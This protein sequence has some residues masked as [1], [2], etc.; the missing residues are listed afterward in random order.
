MVTST[1]YLSQAEKQTRFL[2][3]SVY[4]LGILFFLN[5]FTPLRLHFDM[6]RYFAIKDCIESKCPPGADP[7]DYLPYGYTA[8]LL[9]LSKLGILKSFTIVFVNC[10]Y[11]FG[12]LFF[13]RKIFSYIRSPFLLFFLVLM[14]WTM[15]KFVT[16]PLSE[17]QY[18]FFSLAAIYAF[19]NFIQNKNIWYLLF[20]FL[21]AGLAFLTRTVGVSLVAAIIVS[22]IWEFRK[23]L[24]DIIKKN[25][26]LVFALLICVIIV[27]IFSKQLGLNHYTG[28]MSKQFNEGLRFSDVIGWHFSEWGEI[29]LNTSRFKVISLLSVSFANWIFIISGIL[30][31]SGFVYICFIKK[32]NIPFIVKSYLFFYIIL[33][34]NWPFQDPRFW[35]PVIPL[36]AAVISQ[37]S[38]SKERLSRLFFYL[39]LFVYSGLGLISLAYMTY[40]SF[41]KEEFSK[42][43]AKGVYRNEY[44]THFFG[45]TL[46]DTV[47]RVDP[48]L[49]DFLN[50]YDK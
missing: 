5:C 45:K 47:T 34:F 41:N 24:L 11:L 7:N 39:W 49:V 25:R 13:V 20:A 14:N 42:T 46:S 40:T 38:F 48:Y 26:I 4:V 2:K 18:L 12:G 16:H 21:M 50:K 32:S 10:L 9:L 15:I 30:G 3:W 1:T 37:Y 35:V 23:Q 31:I 44:E 29:L 8:L 33:L 6:L 19:Y 36:I 17:L 27:L 22:L 43:Q 28:V